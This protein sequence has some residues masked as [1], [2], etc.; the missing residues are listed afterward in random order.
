MMDRFRTPDGLLLS[1]IS[2]AA[3]RRYGAYFP[4]FR[5][6][7]ELALLRGAARILYQTSALGRGAVQGLVS[8]IIGDGFKYRVNGKPGCPPG[9]RTAC[10]EILDEDS[11]Q[12]D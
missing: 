5:T 7:Q 6:W 9:L 11:D 10:Q 2:I 4:F 12:Q 8:Y 3:D 1:A